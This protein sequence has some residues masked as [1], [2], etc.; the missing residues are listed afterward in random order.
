MPF[1]KEPVGP[2]IDQPSYLVCAD[3]EDPT[4]ELEGDIINWQDVKKG[5]G[6]DEVL[7]ENVRSRTI[8]RTRFDVSG[9][10]LEVKRAV[11]VFSE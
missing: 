5:V 1:L 7:V 11:L 8:S 3:T 4:E 9:R 10:I 6:W 2:H